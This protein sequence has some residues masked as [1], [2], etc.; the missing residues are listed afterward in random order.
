MAVAVAGVT[1]GCLVAADLA[2]RWYFA[3]RSADDYR[4]HAD[5]YV[6]VPWAKQYWDEYG[7][8]DT[9][10]HSYVYWRHRPFDGRFITIDERGLRKTSN[11]AEC[12][13]PQGHATRATRIFVFGGST[14]WGVGSR[15]ENTIPSLVS[16]ALQEPG[17]LVACVTNFGEVGYVMTQEVFTLVLELEQGRRPDIVVF[18]DGYNDAFAAFQ[19]GTA[20]SPQ[21]EFHRRDTFATRERPYAALLKAGGQIVRDSGMYKLAERINARRGT[22]ATAGPPKTSRDERLA[23]QVVSVYSA[24]VR[25]V[26]ALGAAYGFKSLFYWQPSVFSKRTLTAWEASEARRHQAGGAFFLLT[27]AALGN[28]HTL[29]TQARVHDLSQAF[30]DCRDAIFIDYVHLSEGANEIISSHIAHDLKLVIPNG[31]SP[32][33]QEIPGS[34]ARP[35]RVGESQATCHNFGERSHHASRSVIP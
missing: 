8:L 3:R 35:N 7:A 18:L 12:S 15:N 32:A 30:A 11:P 28:D 1:L 23:A 14:I 19:S 16:R 27:T 33:I 2:L 29:T 10:W 24:N 6:A 17:R 25:L 5:S 13:A 26:E 9:E 34:P 22:S 31:P 4:V 20:G 21:N